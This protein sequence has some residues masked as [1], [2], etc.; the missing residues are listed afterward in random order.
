MNLRPAI[1]WTLATLLAFLAVE[2][3]IFRTGWYNRWLEPHSSAGQVEGYL[4]WLAHRPAG[5]IPEVVVLG[6]SRIGH[7]LSACL[8]DAAAGH[9]LH[10]WNLGINGTLPRD[11]YYMLRDA[12]PDHRRFAAVVLALDQYSDEDYVDVYADRIVDLNFLIGRL[13]VTD[14]WEF[15]SS[16]RSPENRRRALLGCLLKGVALGRDVR[17]LLASWSDR[18]ARATAWREHG[19][20]DLNAFPGIG[21]DLRGLQA[22]WERRVITFPPGIDDAARATIQATVMPSWPPYTGETTRYRQRWLPKIFDLYRN[23]PT[24]VILLELPR[25]PL[26]KPESVT[27]SYFLN[28][29]LPRDGVIALDRTT[30]RDLERPEFFFDGLHLNRAGRAIFS[31]RLGRNVAALAGIR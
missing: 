27:P 20:S 9:H 3:L 25:A 14:C 17:E 1:V 8:A 31:E 29:A 15:A 30:F 7:G 22:D 21:R 11:W 16:M 28:A 24:R 6:D 5:S 19:L 23:S 4:W 13:R 26:P 12:D 18:L 10:F 2:A